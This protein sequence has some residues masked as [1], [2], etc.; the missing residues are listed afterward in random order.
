MPQQI[1][2]LP[3]PPTRTDPNNFAVR[4]DAFLAALPTF[5]NEANQLAIE[6]SAAADTA[7]AAQQA[8]PATAWVSG[9]TYAVGNVRYDPTDFLTYRRKTAGAGTTRPGLD[10]TNWQLI[11]GTGDVNS[12]SNQTIGG[13]KAFSGLCTFSNTGAWSVG[14]THIFKD[15]SGNVGFGTTSPGTKVHA[16]A[17]GAAARLRAQSSDA[18]GVTV[19]MLADSSTAGVLSTNTNH[20]LMFQTNATERARIDTAG[21]MIVGATS[22]AGWGAAG[23]SV[24]V[25]TSAGAAQHCFTAWNTAAAGTR[26]LALFGTGSTFTINGSITSDGTT[27][28]YVTT[29]DARRK[30]NIMDAPDAGAI[31]DAIRVRSFDWDTGEHVEHGFV[32]QELVHQ[33]PAAVLIGDDGPLGDDS[34]VWGVDASKLVP[35]LVRELQSLRARLAAAGL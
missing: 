2:A 25:K 16:V 14:G 11:S 34:S 9:T 6:A 28:S 17:S 30:A 15:A 35:L 20:P 31:I 12:V 27:T 1:T 24:N 7:M 29:S 5:A 10:P 13:T 8:S 4:A 26:F 3:T 21:A 19:E 33:A 22:T 23:P 18:S 32:A